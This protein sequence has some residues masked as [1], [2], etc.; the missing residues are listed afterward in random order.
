[1]RAGSHSL[2]IQCLT[3]VRWLFED[4][5]HEI[6]YVKRL[7]VTVTAKEGIRN[8]VDGNGGL[9]FV[10]LPYP[11]RRHYPG[12][13][14]PRKRSRTDGIWFAPSAPYRRISTS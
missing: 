14:K 10:E 11:E 12:I 3:L 2:E 6:Y 7:G 5:R 9:R 4:G 13:R 8:P 1:M